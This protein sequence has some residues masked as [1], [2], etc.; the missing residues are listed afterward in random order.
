MPY[1]FMPKSAVGEYTFKAEGVTLYAAG[2]GTEVRKSLGV[3]AGVAVEFTS[4]YQ[5]TVP[6]DAKYIYYAS[7]NG[8]VGYANNADVTNGFAGVGPFRWIFKVT[9]VNAPST[10]FTFGFAAD[11]DDDVTAVSSAAVEAEGEVVG[12][13]NL[14]GQKVSEPT[15]GV[16]VVK[17]ANGATKK[18][19]VK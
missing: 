12:Y 10:A 8:L 13:Y 18:V 16:Y 11:E 3:A 5:T 4:V 19:V 6:T 17:Y 1:V 7:I 15:K 2:D 14:A 9:G